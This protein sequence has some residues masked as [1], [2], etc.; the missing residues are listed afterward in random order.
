MR[1]IACAHSPGLR[2]SFPHQTMRLS[3]RPSTGSSPPGT[4]GLRMFLAMMPKRW[5]V[6]RYP[7]HPVRAGNGR[8]RDFEANRARRADQELQD[9]PPC[10]EWQARRYF[11]D[12]FAGTGP[13]GKVVGVSKVA[14][15]I[16]AEKRAEAELQQIRDELA[17]V[18]RVTT[19]G[20]LTAAIAHEVNQP[21]TG[22]I[23]SGNACLRWLSGETPNLEAARKSVER[24]ISEGNRAAKV[25][26]RLRALVEKRQRSGNG[27]ASTTRSLR[28]CP[29]SMAKFGGIQFRYGP[30]LLTI[31][32]RSR[33]TA[34]NYSR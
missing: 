27:S 22:V 29:S 31:Y 13:I 21:L 25:I 33:E 23:N 14:R 7:H 12:R 11:L 34:S 24:M 4:P 5:L 18:T 32:R 20:E 2:Q 1:P 28:S 17:R 30:N 9:G 6:N 15:D 26:K 3:A 19:L 10:Q 16:T 8:N